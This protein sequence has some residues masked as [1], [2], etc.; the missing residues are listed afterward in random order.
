MDAGDDAGT[1]AY[2]IPGS[3]K[4]LSLRSMSNSDE[5]LLD[6]IRTYCMQSFRFP[7]NSRKFRRSIQVDGYLERGVINPRALYVKRDGQKELQLHETGGR[8]RKDRASFGTAT[9]NR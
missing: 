1:L 2:D 7:P 4:A 8:R 9:R 5:R 6:D 3:F